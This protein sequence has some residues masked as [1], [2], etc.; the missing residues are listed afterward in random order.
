MQE[1]QPGAGHT[2]DER[3]RGS[4]TYIVGTY[5]R[6]HKLGRGVRYGPH[7]PSS[8]SS[9]FLASLAKAEK[10]AVESLENPKQ[11]V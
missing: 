3:C 4:G 5:Q 11:L 6:H 7:A 8:K 1:R 2:D 9:G 10:L